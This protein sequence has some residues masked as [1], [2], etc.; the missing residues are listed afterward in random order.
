MKKFLKYIVVV[1]VVVIFLP[2]HADQLP[3]NNNSWLSSITGNVIHPVYCDY[4]FDCFSTGK[5]F[6][7]MSKPKEEHVSVS[8]QKMDEPILSPTISEEEAQRRME[9]VEALMNQ[10]KL[11]NAVDELVKILEGFPDCLPAQS[12]LGAI[13]LSLQQFETAETF[14]YNAVR[15]SNWTD[16]A[17]VVNLATVL[18]QNG[19]KELALKSVL[20]GWQVAKDA[21]TETRALA[22]A[23]GD[24]YLELN[25][26]KSAAE[27]YLAAAIA[28][29]ND[30]D[31]WL[32]ASTLRFPTAEQDNQI[33]ENVLI[34]AVSKN[35]DSADLLLSLGLIWYRNDKIKD[36]ITLFEQVLRID[37]QNNNALLAIAT[38][39]HSIMDTEAALHYYEI[40]LKRLPNNVSLLANCAMLLHS[41]GR[42]QDAVALANKGYSLDPKNAD[43][44]RA[45]DDLGLSKPV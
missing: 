16:Y 15:L 23:F 20:K 34:T 38:A 26:F 35:P 14:L 32:K 4:C 8:P 33:A 17:S 11:E 28:Y 39:H 40:A 21:G 29:E 1:F 2:C 41:I 9:I 18:R 42:K 37:D 27:W 44:N 12:V 31:L 10:N 36:A 5:L 24:S 3:D 45:F 25:N 22:A 43:V 6:G 30:A 13:L 19:D 7:F